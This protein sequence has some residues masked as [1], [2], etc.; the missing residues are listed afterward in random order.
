MRYIYISTFEYFPLLFGINMSSTWSVSATLYC[1]NKLT[2]KFQWFNSTQHV[3]CWVAGG[4]A[5]YSHSGS[6]T[7][8]VSIVLWCRCLNMI[9]QSLLL[10]ERTRIIYNSLHVCLELVPF[11]SKTTF[12]QHDFI[13]TGK[14]SYVSKKERRTRCSKHTQHYHSRWLTMWKYHFV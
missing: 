4:S 2:S 11:Y 8:K 7:D 12:F 10:Q 3:Q 14:A 5:P 6:H 1:G 13:N 9:F